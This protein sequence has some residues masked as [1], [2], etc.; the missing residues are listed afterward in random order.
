[1]VKAISIGMFAG[2]MIAL[3]IS[4]VTGSGSLVLGS[5]AAVLGSIG[6]ADLAT[7]SA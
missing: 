4:I 3:I 7:R 1:M 6:L 5:V 2:A